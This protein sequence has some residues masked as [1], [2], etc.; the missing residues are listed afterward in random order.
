MKNK[1]DNG[2]LLLLLG[3]VV[4]MAACPPIGVVLLLCI[5]FSDGT[6]TGFCG[7]LTPILLFVI[8]AVLWSAFS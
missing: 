5:V 6:A 7:C 2:S 8:L 1:N 4:I 3:M